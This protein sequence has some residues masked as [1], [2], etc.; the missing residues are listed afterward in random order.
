MLLQAP[1]LGVGRRN[2]DCRAPPRAVHP[3]RPTQRAAKAVHSRRSIA[4]AA[5]AAQQQ[6]AVQPEGEVPGMSAYL[7]GLRWNND[8]L[9]AVIAQVGA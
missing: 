7:D 3:H 4:A 9:V 5:A 1:R 8:G 6:Q 2:A